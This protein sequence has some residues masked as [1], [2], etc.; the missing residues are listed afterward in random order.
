MITKV[1]NSM[2][3]AEKTFFIV[4]A[5]KICCRVVQATIFC[6]MENQIGN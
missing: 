3:V 2:E 4:A 1:T 5:V 6:L